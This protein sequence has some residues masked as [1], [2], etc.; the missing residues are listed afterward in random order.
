MSDGGKG[1]K[2]R[3]GTLPDGAWDRVF[4]NSN[5]CRHKNTKAVSEEFI[6][7]RCVACGAGKN[8]QGD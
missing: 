1:D 5:S 3:L 8:A 7:I 2:R 6:H 4:G